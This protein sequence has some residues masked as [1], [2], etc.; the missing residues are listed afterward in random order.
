MSLHMRTRPPLPPWLAR[1]GATSMLALAL[2]LVLAPGA[3]AGSACA[4][5]APDAAAFGKAMTLAERTLDALDRS[6]AEVVLIARAGADLSTYRLRYS[7]MGYAWRDHPHGRWLVVHELNQCA[8]ADSNLFEQGLGT[9][10]LDDMHAYD[11]RIVVP[12]PAVQARLAAMLASA[13][14]RTLH[15]RRYNMLSYAFSTRYQ[16]SN[17]WLLET[18]AA[19]ARPVGTREQAQAWLRHAGYQPI[20]VEIDAITRLGARVARANVSFDDHPFDRRMAG[21]IDT[22]TV[23]SVLRFV[24]AQDPQATLIDLSL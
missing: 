4:A 14:P 20:T 2:S 16:N 8:T 22:V 1:L 15:E 13:T 19:A 21:H 6:G 17:Q 7:H 10:F 11:T 18:W 23:D 24:Q 12:S 5:R 9:F 3:R